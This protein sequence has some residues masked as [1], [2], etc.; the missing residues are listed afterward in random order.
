MAA[1]ENEQKVAILAVLVL[2]ILA[3]Q[4]LETKAV[5][6]AWETQAMLPPGVG[7]L[8]PESSGCS[9]TTHR[10]Q[11]VMLEVFRRARVGRKICTVV[12]HLLT[13]DVGWK[14]C[15][16]VVH[17][18]TCDVGWKICRVVVHLLTCDGGLHD[19]CN[20]SAFSN[21]AVKYDEI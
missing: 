4:V 6:A 21:V 19:W 2:Q 1:Q 10:S 9:S 12:V 7:G 16:A 3:V 8:Q 14:I 11:K 17:L 13:C 15:T 20:I 18:L 5:M